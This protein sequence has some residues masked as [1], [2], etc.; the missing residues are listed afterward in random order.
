M[1]ASYNHD[2]GLIIYIVDGSIAV[3]G[4]FV[5][6]RN[7]SL[8]LRGAAK[9]VLILPSGSKIPAEMLDD[10]YSV[11]FLPFGSLRR[12]FGSV[13]QYPFFIFMS[14]MR[15]RLM[16]RKDSASV[17]IFNDF[18]FVHGIFVRLFGYRGRIY[19]WVRI[20][21]NFLGRTLSYACLQALKVFG[22]KF[23]G[24]SQFI[25]SKLPKRVDAALLYDSLPVVPDLGSN[26]PK[27]VRLVYISN[28]I[29]GK[30]QEKAV[31]VA[32]ILITE[33]P[34]LT[35]EFYGGDMGLEKNRAWKAELM[36]RVSQLGL[37]D[38]ITFHDFTHDPFSVLHGAYAALNFSQSESF[39]MTVLEASAAG[40]PV[41]CTRSGGPAEIVEEGV[42][43]YLVALDDTE[44]MCA[45]LR[46]LIDSP[47]LARQMGE[48]GRREF[49]NRFS[50]DRYQQ[51]L[52]S[53][54]GITDH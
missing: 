44:A 29:K 19:S 48:A 42:S 50:F 30:G 45:A 24:V 39:S 31:A 6:A 34:L 18:Y 51:R 15:I 23:V 8:A 1:P 32:S 38:R 28:Y 17:L 13:L 26:I 46:R 9:V 41:V 12:A 53:I 43:G 49:A 37:S 7:I 27:K 33:Y 10:F 36:S 54:L 14:S 25:L 35:L 16:M 4:A 3:T 20:D 22:V 40:V 52:R 5:G 2:R 21:P 11:R 47:Q